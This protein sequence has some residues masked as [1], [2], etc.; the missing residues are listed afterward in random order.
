MQYQV[1]M[2]QNQSGFHSMIPPINQGN[3]LHGIKPDL[4][5][6]MVPKSYSIPPA[7]YV[8]SAYPS[9]PGFRHP[10]TYP[11]GMKGH[12]YLSRSTSSV[13]PAVVSGNSATSPGTSKSLGGQVEGIHTHALYY[14]YKFCGF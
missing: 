8:G 6:N 1:P 4:A 5:P 2:M 9:V 10:L 7:S 3:A 12:W 11:G 13:P 14:R